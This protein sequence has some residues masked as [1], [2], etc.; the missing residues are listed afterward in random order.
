MQLKLEIDKMSVAV[1]DG[2]YRYDLTRH[3]GGGSDAVCF[4]MLNPSTADAVVDDPTVRRCV[5][6]A[7][8]WGFDRLSVVN[9]F[10]LRATNPKELWGHADPVGPDRDRYCRARF[11]EASLVVCAWGANR[12][13]GKLGADREILDMISELGLVPHVLR[14]TK[15]GAPGHPLYLPKTLEPVNWEMT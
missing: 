2:E 7:K 1:T 12:I 11:E 6:F 9:L 14:L 4:V 13:V 3:W 8:G 15:G 5:G 10:A